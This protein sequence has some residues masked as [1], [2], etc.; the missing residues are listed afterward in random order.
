MRFNK[1]VV[2]LIKKKVIGVEVMM[3]ET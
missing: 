2:Q 1:P 3:D